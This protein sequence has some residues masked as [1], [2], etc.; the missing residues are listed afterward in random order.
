MTNIT[1]NPKFFY[2]YKITNDLDKQFYIGSHYGKIND[3]YLGS[4]KNIKNLIKK[5]GKT[6]FNK[7]II[8][9]C[10]DRLE[11][12]NKEHQEIMDNINNPYCLNETTEVKNCYHTQDDKIKISE[13]SKCHWKDESYRNKILSHVR[14]QSIKTRNKISESL[15]LTHKL[16]KQLGI[17]VTHS[18][19]TKTKISQTLKKTFSEAS[20][21]DRLIL[22]A[23][24]HSNKII[25]AKTNKSEDFDDL[26]RKRLK[27][28]QK[29]KKNK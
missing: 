15:R 27:I 1:A 13:A 7:E 21:H 9:I 14:N 3:S 6:H 2:V 11:M 19:E 24:K 5:Y 20:H 16:K 22:A 10:D 8:H 25:R 29:L 23:R 26:W 4:G 12:I 28:S 18:T 17:S